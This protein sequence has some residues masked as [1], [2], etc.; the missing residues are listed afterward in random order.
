M[1]CN[2]FGV[3]AGDNLMRA[4]LM[5]TL[6]LGGMRRWYTVLEAI[7]DYSAQNQE[8]MDVYIFLTESQFCRSHRLH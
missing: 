1:Q 8:A 3:H 7:A 5:K 6:R 4:A 2:R